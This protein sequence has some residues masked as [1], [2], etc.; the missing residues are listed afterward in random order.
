MPRHSEVIIEADSNSPTGYTLRWEGYREYFG[1]QESI[2]RFKPVRSFRFISVYGDFVAR[3]ERRGS[4]PYWYGFKR[5]GR[6]VRKVYLGRHWRLTLYG[7][8]E[9]AARLYASQP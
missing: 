7:L 2:E 4:R 1:S 8:E 6:V 9:A 3:Q 5:F